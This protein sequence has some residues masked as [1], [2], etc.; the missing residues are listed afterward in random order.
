MEEESLKIYTLNV[1]QKIQDSFENH[2]SKF[3]FQK[4]VIFMS[5][6]NPFL[7]SWILVNTNDSGIWSVPAMYLSLKS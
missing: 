3:F 7:Y 6:D 2:Y 1:F 4:N 5:R